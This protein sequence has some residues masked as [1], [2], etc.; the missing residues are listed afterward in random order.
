VLDL[1]GSPAVRERFGFDD[2]DVERLSS[3]VVEAGV[4]WGLDSGHRR[5]WQL[6]AIAQ[7]TW[8]AGVDRLLLGVAMEGGL[9]SFGQ[10]VPFAMSMGLPVVAYAVGS[11]LLFDDPVRLGWLPLVAGVVAMVLMMLA[12]LPATIRSRFSTPTI[13]RGWMVGELGEAMADVRPEGVVRVREALWPAFANRSTP[14][15]AGDR[16][17]VIG[18]EGTRL[19]VEP[20]AGGARDHRERR[21]SA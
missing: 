7:G 17:R 15:T 3:W 1:A 20:E 5:T 21:S 18:I 19:E 13:G 6:G 4:R 16:V 8:R 11:V 12:G 10:V 2:D 14:I 9:H